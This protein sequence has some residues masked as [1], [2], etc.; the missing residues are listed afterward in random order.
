MKVLT[1]PSLIFSAFTVLWG[2]TLKLYYLT[3]ER[4]FHGL[5]FLAHLLVCLSL[6]V[7]CP[8]RATARSFRM[9][10]HPLSV[11]WVRYLLLFEHVAAL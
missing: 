2:A 11:N 9:S 8:C 4:S 7:A 5:V 6:L 1:I 3:K 10:F